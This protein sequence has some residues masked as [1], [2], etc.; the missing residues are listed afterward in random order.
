M[1]RGRKPTPTK[2]KNLRGNPG[3][4]AVNEDEPI[5]PEGIPD[6][7]EGLSEKARKQWQRIAPVLGKMGVLHVTD[8]IALGLLCDA[9]ADWFEA[10]QH[11]EKEGMT[12]KNKDDV[13]KISPWHRIKIDADNRIRSWASEFGLTPASRTKIRTS[14]GS[15]GVGKSRFF[16]S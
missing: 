10:A 3:K 1:G 16:P 7:P 8:F 15:S 9:L 14:K 6:P 13:P 5:V 11:L 12:I 2:L 4:R